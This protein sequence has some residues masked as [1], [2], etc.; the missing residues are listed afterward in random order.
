MEA[1]VTLLES[2]GKVIGSHY[3]E[4][5]NGV[6]W[7]EK[8]PTEKFEMA[9]FDFEK[10]IFYEGAT[11]EEILNN[12]EVPE[13][14]PLWCLRQ[15]LQEENLF[16]LAVQKINYLEEPFKSR[17][18]NFLEYGNFV[19]RNS[20]TIEMLGALLE[21]TKTEIDTLFINADKLEL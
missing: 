5:P 2:S 17:A 14:V 1:P 4:V 3:G 20:P 16:D 15:E 18:L 10:K 9:F 13:K 8:R 6:L 11:E 12:R 21:K 19:H 7:T